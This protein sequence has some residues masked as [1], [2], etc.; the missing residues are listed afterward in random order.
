MTGDSL[1]K[2]RRAIVRALLA[3]TFAW[4]LRGSF[5]QQGYEV[6]FFS[7]GLSVLATQFCMIDSKLVGKP[8]PWSMQ[9]LVYFT[10]PLFVP[11]YLVWTRGWR[12]LHVVVL[13]IGV[14]L[15][16]YYIPAF[17]MWFLLSRRGQQ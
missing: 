11:I 10:W 7:V 9:W 16:A 6:L 14:Y 2:R 4:G 13:Y 15:A 5:Q 12:K 3:L 1:T 8:L 17:G